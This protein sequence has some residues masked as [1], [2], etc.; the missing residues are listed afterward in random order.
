[1][2]LTVYEV[3]LVLCKL[4][5]GVYVKTTVQVAIFSYLGQHSPEWSAFLMHLIP[6]WH[7][8]GVIVRE[9]GRIASAGRLSDFGVRGRAISRAFS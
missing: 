2:P 4:V 9:M 5:P 7:R 8:P 6:T 1:M 3:T